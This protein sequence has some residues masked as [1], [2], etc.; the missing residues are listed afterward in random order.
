RLLYDAFAAYPGVLGG[1]DGPVR[2]PLQPILEQQPFRAEP[3][4]LL[5]PVRHPLQPIVEQASIG[6]DGRR[7]LSW[8]SSALRANRMTL[9]R[10][11]AGTEEAATWNWAYR[12]PA[13]DRAVD[14]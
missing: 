12:Q 7:A 9:A 10:R 6:S 2:H 8:H 3:P 1:P 13:V 14:N 4:D 5:P 11:F